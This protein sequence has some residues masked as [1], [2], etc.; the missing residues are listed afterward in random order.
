MLVFYYT[1]NYSYLTV[2][3]D[4]WA[5]TLQRYSLLCMFTSWCTKNHR[6]TL[7][8]ELKNVGNNDNLKLGEHWI[9]SDRP[10]SDQSNV[11]ALLRNLSALDTQCRFMTRWG[12]MESSSDEED[13]I[14]AV[15][16]HELEMRTPRFWVHDINRK[17]ITYGE[18]HHLFR[19]C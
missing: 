11:R 3:T 10:G 2:S 19:I 9:R 18:F 15:A 6:N 5:T 12:T 4:S 13:V 14:I 16:C 17:R 8:F 7:M 1:E